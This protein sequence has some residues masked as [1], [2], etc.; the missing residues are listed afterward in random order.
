MTGVELHMI[1]GHASPEVIKHVKGDDITIDHTIPAPSTIKCETYSLS[2]AIEL[3]SRRTNVEF[4][5]NN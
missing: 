2:K 5:A 1:L 4:R 3:I